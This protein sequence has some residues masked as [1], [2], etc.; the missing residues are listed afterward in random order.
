MESSRNVSEP[1]VHF[2]DDSDEDDGSISYLG[3]RSELDIEELTCEG[4]R[5]NSREGF[6]RLTGEGHQ[7]HKDEGL[8]RNTGEGLIKKSGEGRHPGDG[9]REMPGGGHTQN[10]GGGHRDD[11][12][13]D[14]ETSRQIPIQLSDGSLVTATFSSLED[15]MPPPWS[16]FHRRGG[17]VEKIVKIVIDRE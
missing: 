10:I 5:G 15:P 13:P 8:R 2:P 17:E 16:V 4:H 3:S 9:H 6:H 12:V 1:I 7:L 14:S 11:R